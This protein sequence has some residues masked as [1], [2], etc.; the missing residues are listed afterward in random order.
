MAGRSL[1][2]L[3]MLVSTGSAAATLPLKPGT[4]VLADVPCTNPPLA[5]LFTYDGRQFSYPHATGCRSIIQSHVGQVYRVQTRCSALG[6]GSRATPTTSLS[7]Y[8][9]A[10]ATRVSVGAGNGHARS[11]FRWC[12]APRSP[13]GSQLRY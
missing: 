10:S 1:S 8:V 12:P 4:Y 13:D 5:A 7:S 11:T 2:L 6:D 3:L 9:I